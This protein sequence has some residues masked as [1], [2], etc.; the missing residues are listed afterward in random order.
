MFR[1]LLIITLLSKVHSDKC[2]QPPLCSC[3]PHVISCIGGDV[4]VFPIFDTHNN[5]SHLD[6]INTS[7]TNM[8]ELKDWAELKTLDVMYNTHMDCEEVLSVKQELDSL[9][10]LTDCNDWEVINDDLKVYYEYLIS[11]VSTPFLIWLLIVYLKKGKLS[12]HRD[13]TTQGDSIV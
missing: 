4:N 6:I 3:M 9:L 10:F 1:I 8:P 7:L 12:I 11:L 2:G 5:I 13:N